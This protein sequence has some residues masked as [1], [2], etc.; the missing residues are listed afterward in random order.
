[1]CLA[2]ASRAGAELLAALPHPD[3]RV[4]YVWVPMLPPDGEAAAAIVAERFAE[5]RA[6]HYWD[7]ERALAREM[8]QA[9][10]ISARDSIG[11]GDGPGF[12]WDVY[13]AYGRGAVDLTRPAFWMHQL[14][15][16]HA[17]RLDA[18]AF[19]SGVE[20]LLGAARS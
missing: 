2:G 11:A 8:G 3:L 15:V 17:P 14:G 18:E 9:L 19:R 16:T 10:R 13:L 12:A 5:P 7:G 4:Y 6:S 1:M 20:R